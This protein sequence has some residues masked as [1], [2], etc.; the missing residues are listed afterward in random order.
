MGAY[1]A[2]TTANGRP[3]A[4]GSG[5][6]DSV[7]QDV[8]RSRKTSASD[9][10]LQHLRRQIDL[11]RVMPGELLPSAATLAAEI[12]VNR[13]AVLNAFQTLQRDGLIVV[14]PGRGGAR[15]IPL[16]ERPIE[17]RLARAI[18]KREG[19]TNLRLLREILDSGIARAVAERGLSPEQL[20]KARDLTVR[21]RHTTDRD[22]FIARDVDFH[23]LLGEGTG[24]D[25]T[26]AIGFALRAAFM[27]GLDA[28]ELPLERL[29]ASN[30]EHE[31]ILAAIERRAPGIAAEHAYK[32]TSASME[33]V[34]STLWSVGN[35]P[36]PTGTE[37][38][39]T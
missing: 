6:A 27:V 28:V 16:A 1:G 34:V 38:T 3:P 12:G 2:R 36:A 25:V 17:H 15:V 22:E 8:D 13:M 26:K 10:A 35:D 32:H 39:R 11:R 31:K 20:E 24:S 5:T 4:S 19:L 18:E 21:M 29:R 7:E 30:V 23:E 9:K 33:A 37:T 14:R